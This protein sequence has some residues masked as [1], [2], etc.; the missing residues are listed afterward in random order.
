M[1]LPG[2]AAAVGGE[3]P[4]KRVIGLPLR[5]DGGQ[6]GGIVADEASGE[7][8]VPVAGVAELVVGGEHAC[9]LR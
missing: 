2:E 8:R 6:G 4:E 1:R 3:A 9:L 7:Q 5:G